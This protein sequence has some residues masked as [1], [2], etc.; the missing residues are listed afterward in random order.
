MMQLPVEDDG[1]PAVV[2]TDFTNNEWWQQVKAVIIEGAEDESPIDDPDAD[3]ATWYFAFIDDA[4]Y[5]GATPDE[6]RQAVP[7]GVYQK[8]LFIVD[9]STFSDPDRVIRAVNVHSGAEFRLLP[10]LAFIVWT[11]LFQG[12]LSFDE[13]AEFAT[14]DPD[15]VY[16]S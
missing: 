1:V 16:R 5:T 7:D 2:R 9:S 14:A 12:N 4:E 3:R 10:E 11:N 8:V 6:L 15:G 13:L